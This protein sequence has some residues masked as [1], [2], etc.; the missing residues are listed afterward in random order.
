M[1]A[2]ASVCVCLAVAP[3][4]LLAD[5]LACVDLTHTGALSL[6]NALTFQCVS[7]GPQEASTAG[8]L[9]SKRFSEASGGPP[10]QNEWKTNASAGPPEGLSRR[11]IGKQT[12][13]AHAEAWSR[14]ASRGPQRKSI[15]KQTVCVGAEA[16]PRWASRG[17]QPQNY[18][19]TNGFCD[20][21]NHL[22]ARPTRDLI[23]LF[24][25][26]RMGLKSV[27]RNMGSCREGPC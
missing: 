27:S 1:G 8:L 11:T 7:A 21:W 22:E 5:T 12:V 10:S 24:K 4:L 13:F 3:L 19:K 9:A 6:W 17:P 18:W 25:R 23:I 26:S 2:P 15:G 16:W 14:W 20:C